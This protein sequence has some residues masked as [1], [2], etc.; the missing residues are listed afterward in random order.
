MKSQNSK[1]GFTLIELIITIAILAIILTIVV[2]TI[3]PAEQLS[4]SR[5]AKRVADL[6]AMTSA[7]NLYLAQATTTIDLDASGD[8]C[9]DESA[10][11]E[12]FMARTNATN[13]PS[14]F[15][16]VTT[17][18]D[19]T[20]GSSGWAPAGI[21][22]TPGGA[23]IAVLPLDPAGGGTTADFWYAYACDQGNKQFEFTA[24]LESSYFQ[25]DLDV[26][27]TDGGNSAATYESGNDPGLDLIPSGY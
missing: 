10:P 18:T 6:S 8:G 13:T 5:D 15:S 17:S 3:N 19:Q 16:T 2:V 20:I 11:D 26:D 23:A 12:Y 7:W 27:A 1:R 24:R 21:V 4:R 9:V 22:D 14:G 25:T